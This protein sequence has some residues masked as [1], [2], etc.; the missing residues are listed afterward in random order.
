MKRKYLN[1]AGLGV[2]LI[3]LFSLREPLGKIGLFKSVGDENYVNVYNWYD[4]IPDEI[5]HEFE[6]EFGIKVR[7]D[8]YDGNEILEAKLLAGHSGYDV[9][10]PSAAPYIAQQ[11]EAGVYQELDKSLLP[12]LKYL[13]PI[14]VEQMRVADPT[15]AYSVPYYWGTFGFAYVEEIILAKMPDA[16]VNSYRMLFDPNVV[17]KFADCGVTLLDESVDIY[18]VVQGYLGLD[19]QSD[20]P[21]DL[22]VAQEHLFKIRPSIARFS[23][24]R[25]VNELASG[26]SCLA[27]AW[28]GDAHTA[29]DLAKDIGKNIHIRYVVPEEGGSIWI[30]AAAIPKNAPHFENAHKFINFMLRPEICARVTN[31]VNIATANKAAIPLVSK[32]IQEDET[33]YPPE[34]IMRKLRLDRTQG[35]KF[36]TLRN[37]LWSQVRL[38]QAASETETEAALKTEIPPRNS[39]ELSHFRSTEKVGG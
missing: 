38:G 33:I 13:D 28:S 29:N 7:Y 35:S 23:G 24:I 12:N 5:L 34:R 20:R 1:I 30:D 21:E 17:S 9:V 10:F 14:V 31:S 11:I 16:P 15:N 25:F 2:L 36:N 19:S 39:P 3:S 4:M 6:T 26:E 22:N 27:Q 32:E 18:P 8:V 37:R